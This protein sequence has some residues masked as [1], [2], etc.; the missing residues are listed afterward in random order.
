MVRGSTKIFRH[1]IS[2][3]KIFLTFLLALFMPR[4]FVKYIHTK[5]CD[6]IYARN[7]DFSLGIENITDTFI[8][9]LTESNNLKLN[10]GLVTNQTGKDQLGRS[11]INILTSKGLHVKKIFIT[12]HEE[13][14]KRAYGAIGKNTQV[15][16]LYSEHKTKILDKNMLKDIDIIMF[17]IQ[18]AEVG[19]NTHITTLLK[20]IDSAA[21][22]KKTVVV[23][24]RPN[25]LGS[26]IEGP[27][28][29]KSFKSD[30]SFASMP[31]HYGMTIGEIALYYNN[32]ISKTKA[33][34][35]IVP[36][37]GY[38]RNSH[39]TNRLAST[40]SENITHISSCHGHSFLGLLKEVEPFSIDTETKN[41]YQIIFAPENIKFP[42]QKWQNLHKILNLYG[43]EN[44]FYR[45]FDKRKN[46]YCSGLKVRVNNINYTKSF[47][48]FMSILEFFK[49][50]DIELKFSKNFDKAVGTDKIRKFLENKIS[51]E[52][53][54][55]HI[56]KKLYIFY[57]Q[58]YKYFIYK[59]Y[60]QIEYL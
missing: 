41:A 52:K 56:N 51:W 13:K 17:D 59:P 34:L 55:R 44:K 9:R 14:E 60:P 39:I 6:S 45:F 48:I 7:S 58:A 1:V 33:D 22:Y 54:S 3:S 11:N 21:Q 36:M 49:E 28:V 43:I 4:I 47:K 12:E 40:L 50:S 2:M 24:D 31:L 35:H 26:A 8:S 25:L 19:N 38:K 53:L 10:I 16:N 27:V 30:I 20:T 18:D 57:N 5:T 37:K 29:D 23:L 15:I 42:K 46:N 32:Q